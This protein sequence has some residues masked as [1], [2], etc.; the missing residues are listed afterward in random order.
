MLISNVMLPE[1]SADLC[2]TTTLKNQEIDSSV[3]LRSQALYMRYPSALSQVWS[4]S[5]IISR[6]SHP[7]SGSYCYHLSQYCGSL[8]LDFWALFEIPGCLAALPHPVFLYLPAPALLLPHSTVTSAIYHLTSLRPN[9]RVGNSLV[10]ET[11][12]CLWHSGALLCRTLQKVF[13]HAT[14]GRETARGLLNLTQG[15]K[16]MGDYLIEFHT[17]AAES[18]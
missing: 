9:K 18:K 3:E 14:P 4:P 17:M 2:Q 10:R 8:L 12:H 5:V 16:T 11:V 7:S 15:G 6:H 1:R 13:D